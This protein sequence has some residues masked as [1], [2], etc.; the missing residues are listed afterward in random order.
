MTRDLD[1]FPELP[2]VWRQMP[3]KAVCEYRV[4]NVDKVPSEDELPV[5]LCNYTD[6]YHNEFITLDME[7]METTA[8]GGEI[9]R[10]GLAV[11]DVVITKDSEAWNDI[12]VPAVI[13]ETAPDLVCGYHLAMLRPVADILDGRYLFRCLQARPMQF[14]FERSASG[15]TRYGL[16]LDAIGRLY[17]PIP[18]LPRQRG[19]A[20][21]LDRET[22]KID[23]MIAAKERLLTL[24]AE[25]RRALITHAVTRGLNP[26]APMKDSGVEWLGEIPEHWDVWR[27][28]YLVP[29][30]EQGWS[31]QC[32]AY[33]AAID[34]WGVVK[35]GCCNNGIFNPDENKTLPADQEVPQELEIQPNDV[36]MSRASGSTE[37]IGSVAVVPADNRGKLLL[38]DKTYRLQV[39]DQ[40]IRRSYL[41]LVLGSRVG[42]HQV[43]QVISGAAGLANN[44]AQS[45][46]KEFVIPVPPVREQDTSLQ[47]VESELDEIVAMT[48]VTQRTTTLLSERRSALIAAAVTG[49]I[50]MEDAA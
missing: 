2:S 43:E 22:A 34:E 26:D 46:L 5:R 12:G 15:V 18:P 19:I 47:Q 9:E 24:L 32:Y 41:A 14:Q 13:A 28:K 50:D 10:F 6:V 8:T 4:S 33:P 38:S 3:L 17:L 35:A 36:L 27:L 49:K 1:W 42:R 44:I 25:K 23:A 37:L 31:P 21:Y 39:D 45:D 20:A 11:R 29:K 40:L 7:L 30:I 16:G 48:A